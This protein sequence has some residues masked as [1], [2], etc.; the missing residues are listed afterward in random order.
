[1]LLG[2][3][4]VEKNWSF[5]MRRFF[6][7]SFILFLT[8]QIFASEWFILKSGEM[9]TAQFLDMEFGSPK[10]SVVIGAVKVNGNDKMET[11]FFND[12]K[13]YNTMPPSIASSDISKGMLLD[14]TFPK[15][16]IA[17]FLR[18]EINGFSGTVAYI[19]V[20]LDSPTMIVKHL[21]SKDEKVSTRVFAIK[22]SSTVF[23]ARA[24]GKILKSVDD[25]VSW[26]TI[27]VANDSD[28]K[29]SFIFFKD[30]NN[31]LVAG[32][33]TTTSMDDNQDELEAKTGVWTTSDGGE[34]WKELLSKNKDFMPVKIKKTNNGEYFISLLTA[35]TVASSEEDKP[36]VLKKTTDFKTFSE[37]KIDSMIAFGDFDITKEGEIWVGG[38]CK[39]FQ[40]CVFKSSDDGN[41]WTQTPLPQIGGNLL[42]V[43]YIKA[44]DKNHI[45]TA[46]SNNAILKYG[47]PNE[48]VN[49]QPSGEEADESFDEIDEDNNSI[50]DNSK[51]IPEKE[52]D[53]DTTG[54]IDATFEEDSG[55]GCSIL[56]F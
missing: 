50:I 9:T 46:I 22:N 19:T 35:E 24:D 17:G 13:N 55:C 42:K 28:V 43:K 10:Y 31:G 47:D 54:D 12:G 40:P 25:G 51:E 36:V 3:V 27:D 1:M 16:N 48:D 53:T 32:Y 37:V 23:A 14:S 45:Y 41:S 38:L 30:K 15:N 20:N 7:F 8:T 18:M 26:K 34:T 52:T 33:N 6:L 56:E 39:G 29:I 4:L 21:F 49:S 2:G 44:I 5:V 11:L